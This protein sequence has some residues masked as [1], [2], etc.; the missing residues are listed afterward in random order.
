MACWAA[1]G[2]TGWVPVKVL[3]VSG[4]QKKVAVAPVD[5]RTNAPTGKSRRVRIDR[6]VNRRPSL[7]GKDRPEKP[8]LELLPDAFLENDPP[9]G[10]VERQI[11][12]E[13]PRAPQASPATPARQPVARDP[14][15]IGKLLDLIPDD[16]VGDRW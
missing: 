12:A 16:H 4:A 7:K 1:W 9:D 2:A 3:R 15:K 14:R 11:E 13:T 5:P 6:L 10:N 8:P